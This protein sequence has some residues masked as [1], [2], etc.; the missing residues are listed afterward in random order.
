MKELER[1]EIKRNILYLAHLCEDF[2]HRINFD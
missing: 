1:E 2:E